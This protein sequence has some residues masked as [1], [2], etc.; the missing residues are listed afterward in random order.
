MIACFVSLAYFC[1]YLCIQAQGKTIREV[2]QRKGR[3]EKTY[4]DPKN[5]PSL[6][7]RLVYILCLA[8]KPSSRIEQYL[9]LKDHRKLGYHDFSF[10]ND[11]AIMDDY[12]VD[13]D[14]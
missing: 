14:H 7:T 11:E 12:I 13:S 5:I 10:V 1:L 9:V 6:A 2:I 8:K 3:S 4:K